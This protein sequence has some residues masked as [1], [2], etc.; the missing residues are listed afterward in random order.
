MPVRNHTFCG[1]NN[2]SWLMTT[3][4]TLM[5]V[6]D[7]FKVTLWVLATNLQ[8]TSVFLLGKSHGERRL[9][10]YGPWDCKE[11]DMTEVTSTS[12]STYA[13]YYAKYFANILFLNL[14]D[15]L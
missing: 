14:H 2:I 10:G 7:V 5:R 1:K 15:I 6:L 3:Y 9:A 13:R 11:S 12:Q 8:L 4:N